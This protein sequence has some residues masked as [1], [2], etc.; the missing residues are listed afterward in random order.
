MLQTTYSE[1]IHLEENIY[2]NKI[3]KYSE[4]NKNIKI[5]LSSNP[6]EEIKKIAE[7]IEK[8]VREENYEYRDIA[9][10]TQNLEN[11]NNTIKA[12]F[13]KYNIPIFI[14]EKT[15]VTENSLIKHVISILEIF[16][17]NWKNEAV[18]NYLKSGF[19]DIENEEIYI[20]ENYCKKNGINRNKWYK[21]DWKENNEQRK[22]IIEP[23][24]KLKNNFNKEKTAREISEKIY[25]YLI[26][27]NIIEKLN[28]KIKK[29]EK[30]GE[31]EKA[32]E[33]KESL[34][35][36]INVLD[37][38][39]IFF[40][41]EQISFEKYKEILKIG[42]TNKEI[43]KIPQII[44][45][46]MLGDIERTKSHKVKIAFIL[47]VNDGYFP[48]VNK[49]EGF[50]ND[51]DRE[52]L[53]KNDLEIAKS[54]LENLY[55]NQFNI[56][57]ALTIPEEKLYISYTST[58]KD[59]AA[60]RPSI[61]ITKIKKIFPKIKEENNILK[62]KFI[63]GNKS[64]T[65]GELLKNI[66]KI[67]NNEKIDDI[68][69]DVYNWYKQNEN[70]KNK[71]EKNLKAINYKNNAEKINEKNIK[72]LYGEK[73]KTSISKLEQYQKCPFS[74]HLK[75]GLKIKEQEEYKLR[76]LDTGSFMHDVLD[77]FFEKA[78]NIKK[79]TEKE[80][81]DLIEEIINEK[82]K[83]EKNSIYTSSAKF[84]ILTN[85]LKNTIKES[86]KHIVYQIQ[87]SDFTPSGTEIEFNKTIEN[88]EIIG[89]V[90]RIDLAKNEEAEYIRII[91][92][93]SSQKNIDLNQVIAGTQIQLLTYIDAISKERAK[94]PAGVLYFN[95][96]EPII[97]EDKNL[98][99]EQIK[100]KIKKSFKMK[101][102]ILAD[103]KV[104]KMMDKKVEKGSSEII[105]VY[106]DKQGS[107]SNTRSSTITKEQ[108]KDLQKTIEKTIKQIAKEILSG[109]IEIKPIYDKK[110]KTTNC[111]YC[112]Y[113]TICAFN[114]KENEYKYIQDKTKEEI[115]EEIKERKDD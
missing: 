76:A 29:L 15:E 90:D 111:K 49:N 40:G 96:I 113:K 92:Y 80:K 38:I 44:D 21:S 109:K 28:K 61:L 41:E 11:I 33:Y 42:L 18:F 63:I 85:K 55:E 3:K 39:V 51:K 4:E 13:N 94:E 22:K 83:L 112:E 103:I 77:E 95:L 88:I 7:K 16:T 73:L 12:I 93:K 17:N 106:I 19:V 25:K 84:I 102:L 114:P 108:F 105:P 50:L 36:L 91:D 75:Y 58:D 98:T 68:W 34:N 82:L 81:E 64:A 107:I 37:E 67:K 52:I 87:I 65:F 45:E 100:E 48:K 71:L 104:I 59:G 14:D 66:R 72:K 9:I 2:N 99:E 27:N 10:I 89:K 57:K 69:I 26:E 70:W 47:G 20:I 97:S 115:L 62:N 110:T 43:G 23:L 74:F 53:K 1:L 86:I 78:E 31:I 8:L 54:T 5:I 35:I 56:Y 46:V 60:L 6:Y 79:I 32:K 30:I 24:L 101:G